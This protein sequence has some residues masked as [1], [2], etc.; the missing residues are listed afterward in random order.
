MWKA[1]KTTPPDENSYEDAENFLHT[2][3]QSSLMEV[4][5]DNNR[6]SNRHFRIT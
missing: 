5:Q 6:R 3:H 2:S 4:E 1:V